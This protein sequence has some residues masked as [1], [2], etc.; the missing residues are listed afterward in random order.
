M[1]DPTYYKP[2]QPSPGQLLVFGCFQKGYRLLFSTDYSPQT[3]IPELKRVGDMNDSGIAQ[4]AYT[5]QI[6]NAQGSSRCTAI[7]DIMAWNST[8]GVFAP[9]NDVPMNA[10]NGKV[11]IA[12]LDKDGILEVAITFTPTQDSTLGPQRKTTNIWDWDGINYRLALIQADAPAYRIHAV[13]DGDVHFNQGDWRGAIKLFDR[14][15]DDGNLQPWTVPNETEVLR[16]YATYKKM[17]A[18]V[19]QGSARNANDVLSTLQSENPAGSAGESYAVL[20]QSF[21]DTYRQTR[22]R[23]KTC[24]ATLGVAASR[25][26]L[27]TVLNSFGPANR[28]YALV[29]LCPFSDK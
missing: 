19:A 18:Y 1:Y 16:A 3:M 29:D 2:G 20:G 25:P 15:R 26:D 23:K 21:M 27:L 12:D 11:T 7:M 13:H 17:L 22:D 9:L 6:C 10:T 5:Q 4:L 24:A 8:L 14:V 28:T